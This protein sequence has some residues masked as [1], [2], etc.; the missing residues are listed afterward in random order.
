MNFRTKLLLVIVTDLINVAV[1]TT[2]FFVAFIV[3]HMLLIFCPREFTK[4]T[5]P[6]SWRHIREAYGKSKCWLKLKAEEMISGKH[7]PENSV[8]EIWRNQTETLSEMELRIAKNKQK[9]ED[10]LNNRH[11]K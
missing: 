1:K 3:H 2:F 10:A 5:P 9:F 11:S 8:A 6:L 4:E 7:K